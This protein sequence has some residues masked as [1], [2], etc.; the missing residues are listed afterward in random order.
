MEVYDADKLLL[1]PPQP[2]LSPSSLSQPPSLSQSQSQM[3]PQPQLQPQPLYFKYSPSS[4]SASANGSTSSSESRKGSV[5]AGMASV[6]RGTERELP[7]LAEL[8]S[9]QGS[10]LGG[11]G[12]AGGYIRLGARL[13]ALPNSLASPLP[14][15]LPSSLP[16]S[17]LGTTPNPLPSC[18]SSSLPSPLTG[19]VTAESLPSSV[20]GSTGIAGA[21]SGALRS[22]TD[23]GTL[24]HRCPLCEKAFK[25]KSWLRRH[26]LSHSPERH[27]SCPWCL[28]KHKRKDNLLQHMKV[29]HTAYVLQELK[30]RNVAIEGDVSGNSIRTLL[31][32]GRLNKDDVKR[33]LNGLIE[34]RAMSASCGME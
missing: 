15:S 25:R 30:S 2:S 31:C 1:P 6:T 23:S 4:W 3:Q 26:L 16:N 32:E 33:V 14:N 28:S 13:S 7:G 22:L 18:L 21:A 24:T 34:L 8:I 10:T 17:R 19:A 20:A 29:K 9:P 27:F 5:A 11:S 12:Q